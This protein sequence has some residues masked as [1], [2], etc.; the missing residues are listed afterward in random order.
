MF[1][2]GCEK[3]GQLEGRFARGQAAVQFAV[4]N[5]GARQPGVRV[6]RYLRR[7]MIRPISFEVSVV[8]HDG[9]PIVE[10]YLDPSGVMFRLRPSRIVENRLLHLT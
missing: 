8:D 1:I 3:F 9:L 7:R 5:P 10:E 6:K 4:S 2:G